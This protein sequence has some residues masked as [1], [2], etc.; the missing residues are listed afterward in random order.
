MEWVFLV[1]AVGLA[2][3][4]L[5]AWAQRRLLQTNPGVAAE[6]LPPVSI[7]KPLR[8]TD[9]DLAANLESFFHLDYPRYEV[10]FGVAAEDDPAL[11]VA[12]QV[13]A[14]HPEIR[15]AVVVDGRAV[16]YNPKVNNLANLERRAA[17]DVIL[18]SD[19]N[20]RVHPSFLA[21]MVAALE[22]PGV[23]LVSS[24]VSAPAGS[25]LGARLEGL[26]LNTYVLGG[27]AAM[28]R[29]GGVCVMGKS[30]LMRRST[31]SEIGGFAFLAR[32][33]AEDQVCGQE[34]AR[35]GLSLALAPRPVVNVTGRVSVR[36]F[37][38][39]QLRWAKIRRHI[40]PLGYCGEAVLNP[41]FL[42]AV[43]AA[44]VPSGGGLGL[45]LVTIVGK[46]AI[47]LASERA[48]GVAR[49]PLWYPFL[50]TA[51]DLLLGLAW[52]VPWF[53]ASVVWRGNR[54]R[55]GRRTRLDLRPGP[56]RREGGIPLPATE[57]G[58]GTVHG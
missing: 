44:V 23:G 22:R 1:V 31:L 21:E 11:E 36:Q 53:D 47:D 52:F 41:I 30:M 51:K 40:S 5:E 16:G 33:L 24:P 39:R 42:A 48:L 56:A 20:V 4:A 13:A 26:Q 49:S 2:V 27:V 7:L 9:S 54:L 50:S 45:L 10:L 19:S 55:I 12:R 29:L 46:A 57:T 28:H 14:R 17:F 32:F 43:A 34:I 18:I 15:S 58:F 35:R 8:G 38:S 6:G 3:L 37:L 25:N